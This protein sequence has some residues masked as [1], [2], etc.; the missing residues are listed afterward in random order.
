VCY[1]VVTDTLIVF[2]NL[3][4][5]LKI[6]ANS[7]CPSVEH[8]DAC[9]DAAVRRIEVLAGDLRSAAPPLRYLSLD[10]VGP[11]EAASNVAH[12]EFRE[13]IRRAQEHI[14]AGTIRSITLSQRF[15]IP[16]QNLD[17]FDG[18]R[19]LRVVSPSPYMYYLRFPEL[20]VTGAAPETL[21]R[22]E[23]GV[24]ELRPIS[25]MR[26]RG[27]T[28]EED[29]ALIEDLLAEERARAE[30]VLLVDMA[31]GDLGR[32]A[33][34]GSTEVSEFMTVEGYSDF[35][36]LVSQVSAHLAPG[37]GAMDVLRATFPAPSVTGSPKR[38]AM[39]VIDELEPTSRGIFGGAVGYISFS[40]NLDLAM[41][42]RSILTVGDKVFVQGTASVDHDSDA[43]AVYDETVARA[44]AIA[45][46]VSI[47]KGAES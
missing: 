27:D 8:A 18:Y 22:L 37:Q 4:Q 40:G 12:E 17:P 5:T 41:A 21:V 25:G 7:Y 3:R 42:T 38:R 31:R 23:G 20:L 15:E 33:A 1:F 32:V 13:R 10:D 45:R 29:E 11:V 43:D 14:R 39:R 30:Q 16:R 46:A 26:R 35:M 36:H 34:V 19:A 24:V 6:V 9:Y 2:D 47:A 44:T 28:E